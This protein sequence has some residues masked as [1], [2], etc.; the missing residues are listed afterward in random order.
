MCSGA[1][2]GIA[3]VIF[4]IQFPRAQVVAVELSPDNYRV[5]RRNTAFLPNV[6]PINAGLHS[7]IESLSFSHRGNTTKEGWQYVLNSRNKTEEDDHKSDSNSNSNGKSN[8]NSHSNSHSDT[9]NSPKEGQKG[10]QREGNEGPKGPSRRGLQARKATATPN[11]GA[12]KG[13]QD[14]PNK[15]VPKQTQSAATSN[16]REGQNGKGA[17]RF[18]AGAGAGAVSEVRGHVHDTPIKTVTVDFVLQLFGIPSF[19]FIKFDVEGSEK[20]IFSP[21]RGGYTPDSWLPG[22]QMLAVETH[23]RIRNGSTEAVLRALQP[24]YRLRGTKVGEY[25]TWFDFTKLP[26]PVRNL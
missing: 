26:H 10:A 21:A 11:R 5:L 7:A 18:V 15:G 2:I 12:K 14:F 19:D 22:V 4:A 1:N 9:N 3:T 16:S 17:S 6:R 8:S 24:Y 20:D 25:K 23:D 13:S